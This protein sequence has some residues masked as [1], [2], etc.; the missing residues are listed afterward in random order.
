[1]PVATLCPER[2]FPELPVRSHLP[3]PVHQ[4]DS[5]PSMDAVM[6]ALTQLASIPSIT[7]FPDRVLELFRR[8]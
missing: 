4:P 2:P 3:R 8:P 5:R 7:A 6:H 1:M